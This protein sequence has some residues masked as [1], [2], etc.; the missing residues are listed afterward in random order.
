MNDV[1]STRRSANGRRFAIDF[2]AHI[3]VP[4][5]YAVAFPHSIACKSADAA[6][7]DESRRILKARQE[8]VLKRMSDVTER[9]ARMNAMGVDVQVLS[10]SQ[11]HESTWWAEPKES[12]RLERLLNDHIARVVAANPA[13]FVG[14]GGVPLPTPELA[15]AE[16]R[17]CVRELGLAGVAI[18][19]M[20]RDMELGDVRL[21][22]FW[23]AAAELGAIVYIHPAGNQGARFQNFSLW[24]SIGQAYEEAMAI[25][26]LM[27]E[28]VLDAFPGVKICISHGGG[29]MPFYMGRIFRNYAEK[30]TTRVNMT[31]SPIDYLRMLY[32]DSCVYE[33]DVLAQLV[34]RV[35]ADRVVL[36]S[37]YP[38]GDAMPVE[39]VDSAAISADDKTKII[40]TN[41]AKLLGIKD[42]ALPSSTSC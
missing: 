41:A 8:F 13:R 35:G 15:V 17:R 24:N 14:L 9:I 25:A 39:F 36:G 10:S 1:D 42:P 23:A 7:D 29:Y 22:P 6:T 37:D 32:F 11:V 31:K 12:L 2:H 33:T 26:S 18:S 34:K 19:T 27:Y 3:L 5:V 21:R 40:G 28:G 16:L 30:P 38:V 4:E 20:A